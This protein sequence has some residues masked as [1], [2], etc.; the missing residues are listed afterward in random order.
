MRGPR[1]I[2]RLRG[3]PRVTAAGIRQRLQPVEHVATGLGDVES[4]VGVS[5]RVVDADRDPAERVD[6]RLESGEVD[7]HVVVDRQAELV[8]QRL[9]QD[10]WSVVERRVD[11]PLAVVARYL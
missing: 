6:E 10:F 8:L 11:P 2:S 7:L 5:C 3:T 4:G 1:A 9:H